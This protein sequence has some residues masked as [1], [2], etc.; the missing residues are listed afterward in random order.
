M[1]MP[2]AQREAAVASA[3]GRRTIHPALYLGVLAVTV[4]LGLAAIATFLCSL[5]ARH[6]LPP[7][8]VSGNL[9][10]DEKIEFIRR[11]DGFTCEVLAVGSSMTLNNLHSGEFARAMADGERLLNVG[12]WAMKISDSREMLTFALERAAP[13]QVVMVSGPMDFYRDRDHAF[14]NRAKLAPMVDGNSYPWQVAKNLD[15]QYYWN[16]RMRMPALRSSTTSY[17]SVA[18][19]A[20]GAVLLDIH[21]PDVDAIRWNQ[22]VDCARFDKRQYKAFSELAADLRSRGIAL[23]CAQ[24]PL[25]ADSIPS[26]QLEP[27]RAHWRTLADVCSAH[28]HRFVNVHERL[29]LP[30]DCF[31]DYSHLN[32]DGAARFTASLVEALAQP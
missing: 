16:N 30:E 25:R 7:L 5:A 15:V 28:G 31:A 23:V 29:E 22:L 27:L 12:A 10:F 6:M 14:V 13:R 3:V 11:R 8:P 19:D 2:S 32:V 4:G 26:G 20:S 21:Q 9:A 18:F 17:E 24:A 1:E